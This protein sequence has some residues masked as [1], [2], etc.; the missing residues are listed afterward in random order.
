MAGYGVDE[1]TV[2]EKFIKGL[3]NPLAKTCVKMDTLDTW[4]EW[5]ESTRKH[6]D[7]YLRWRQILGVNDNKKDQSSSKKKDLNKWRQGFNSK[8]AD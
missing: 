7:V 5:K 3:P 8:C 2:L 6:Q 4:E 1:P